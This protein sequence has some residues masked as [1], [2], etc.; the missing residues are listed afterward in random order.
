MALAPR[1]DLRQSQSLVMT[2]QLQQAIK[3]LALSSMEIEAFIAEEI[4]RNPLLENGASE[5]ATEA[6]PEEFAALPTTQS[7][8]RD[9][10]DV[11]N[12][13][14]SAASEAL[15]VDFAADTFHH[16][17]ASDSVGGA[18]GMLGLSGSGMSSEFGGE[19]PDFDS[20]AAPDIS[21]ARSPDG[22]GR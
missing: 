14:D 17:C 16:D 5:P 13:S 8:E 15:D 4:E 3:L 7:G 10:G 2:P 1:L 21:L 12:G 9:S 19:G 22:A 11:L 18:D 6:L 20:F